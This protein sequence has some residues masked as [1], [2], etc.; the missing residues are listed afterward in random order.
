M[1]IS[2]TF[3]IIFNVNIFCIFSDLKTVFIEYV[4]KLIA[5]KEIC[6]KVMKLYNEIVY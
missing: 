6:L 5:N 2:L 4:D 1:Q 3:L